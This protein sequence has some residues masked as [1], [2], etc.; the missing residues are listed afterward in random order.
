[1]RQWPFNGREQE[2]AVVSAAFAGSSNNAVVVTAPAGLGKTRLAREAL[3]RLG[4]RTEGVGATHSA[5]AMPFGALA[6]LLP[7]V[8]PTAAPVGLVRALAARVASWGGRAKVAIGVD[9]AHLLDDASS[10]VI[11]HVV[12]TGTA[13][14]VMTARSGE[15]LPDSLLRL[16]R[17]DEAVLLELSELPDS[18]M[19]SLI[20]Q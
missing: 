20:D 7:D 8:P 9:D 13:F 5:T 17:E 15:P 18:V 1:M 14:V 11:A 6:H 12:T 19:D 2:I 3:R 16:G 10:T 4:C